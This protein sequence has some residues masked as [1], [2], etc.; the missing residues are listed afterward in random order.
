M[1]TLIRRIQFFFAIMFFFFT[2]LQAQP[3]EQDRIFVSG[4]IGGYNASETYLQDRYGA[5]LRFGLGIEAEV[6]KKFFVGADFSST[7]DKGNPEAEIE[8]VELSALGF[9]TIRTKT[10][11]FKIGGG[12]TF[13]DFH[14]KYVQTTQSPFNKQTFEIKKSGLGP[15]LSFS[16]GYPLDEIGSAIYTDI[17]ARSVPLSG[18]SGDFNAGGVSIVFGLRQSL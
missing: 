12:F 11:M 3:E 8:L 4:F 1:P 14:D 7:N 10:L 16:I 6:G 13:I 9:Y 5:M 18:A 15:I 2:T 17:R